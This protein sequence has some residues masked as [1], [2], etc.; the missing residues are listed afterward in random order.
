MITVR[1]NKDRGHFKNGWL[2]SY[3][4]FSFGEY[5]DPQHMGFSALRVINDDQVAP[6]AGFPT[7]PHRDMEIVTYVLDG[8][9]EHKD[10]LG[11]GSV[12]RPGDIQRMSAGT[13]ILHSEF[14]PQ[15]DVGTRL[16][17]IWILPEKRGLAPS[18]EQINVPAA[19]RTGKLKLVGS[20][21]GRDG[22][23]TIHQDTSLY[24]TILKSGE[25]ASLTLAKNRAAWVQVAKG[26]ITLNGEVLAEGDGAAL[27]DETALT[28]TATSDAEVLVFDLP[29][30][31][32]HA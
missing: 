2:D 22:S 20:P 11:T 25:S 10:S 17:Q 1:K 27:R 32:G 7:H 4:S 30:W 18:Y 21:D 23:V 16:L 13:G 6:G 28:L 8:A 14:N 9:L 15:A 19:E 12:I 5:Y 29:P 31:Q 24:A 26:S 3:H